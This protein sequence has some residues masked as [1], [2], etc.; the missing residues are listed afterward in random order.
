MS[1]IFARI[2]IAAA[3]V[4]LAM[5]AATWVGAGTT[6]IIE[7]M[8][9]DTDS[10]NPIS[11]A[12]VI[13]SGTNLTTVTDSKGYFVITNVPPGE[14]TVSVEMVGYAAKTIGSVQVTMDTREQLDFEVAQE[15]T[16][17]EAVVISRPRSMVDTGL[18]NTLYLLTAQQEEFT[19]TD[20]A[21][22]HTAAGVLSALPGV[23]IDPNGS[24]QIHLR[25]GRPD[26]SGWY[27]EGIPITDPNTGMF[28]T[29]LYT[30]GMS[31]FQTY[32][33][34]FGVEYGN[35]IAGVLNEVKRTGGDSRGFLFDT[36]GGNQA[37]RLMRAEFGGGTPNS[38]N[39]FVSGVT[40]SSDLDGPIVKAQD[41]VDGVAKLVWPAKNDTVTVLA[42][43]GTVDG[44]LSL[45]HDLGNYDT[46]TTHELDFMHQRYAVGAV[47]WNH[48][49][50]PKTFL[51][52]RPYYLYT[53]ILQNGMGASTGLPYYFDAWSTRKGLQIAYTSQLNERHMLKT[54]WS[55]LNSDN[56]YYIYASFGG[57][58]FPM[59]HYQADVPTSQM[60]MY[61]EDSMKLAEEWTLSAG[62]RHES[63]TYD[64][65]GRYYVTGAGYSGDLIP[66]V[67]ESSTTPRFG[68]SYAPND[69][70]AWKLSWGKYTKWVPSSVVQK[71]Y[72]SPD[73]F[74]AEAAA[75]G[76][77][78]TAPQQSTAME[79][80]YEKQV[81]DTVA[82][83][84]T[85]FVAKYQN[86][87]DLYT[88][89]SGIATYMNL[90]EGKSSGVEIALQKRMSSHWEGWLSYTY[91]KTQANRAAAGM[92]SDMFYTSWDQRSTLSLVNCYKSGHWSHSLRADLGSGRADSAPAGDAALVEHA[93][94]Y[95]I[96]NYNLTYELENEP[97]ASSSIY[98]SIYNLLDNKQALQYRWD[99]GPVRVMDSWVPARFISCG[100]SKN[101]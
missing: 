89:G 11:G 80:S 56:N 63:I 98:V 10:G 75:P 39:Y 38:F 40:Q 57:W 23:M 15:A 31:K 71:V 101:F 81:N 46:P 64:R 41:Y 44:K 67:T 87:S 22:I 35:A 9:T 49:F 2:A 50:S 68:L 78:S 32:T 25:G 24:G 6:G 7:G 65:T 29:N 8:V 70:T 33:G 74:Y 54:G 21:S 72:F 59:Y 97:G 42:M 1:S 77:G 91:Q 34:G 3:A 18:V 14:Y 58:I 69:R 93:K 62:L 20:P 16:A 88:D 51:T 55:M 82:Y 95:M 66:D 99:P 60:D 26:Q 94:P 36:E 48:S 85:P 47:T 76:L 83:R 61:I 19:R 84:I 43:Q 28:G 17:E 45:Y 73:D 86:L 100:I 92:T 13:V 53:N 4:A 90:G 30:T 27:V 79:L 12:N 37:H 52:V 96:L 5:C